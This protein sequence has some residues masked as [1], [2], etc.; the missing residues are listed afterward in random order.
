[1]TKPILT[2]G[3]SENCDYF[4]KGLKLSGMGSEFNVIKSSASFTKFD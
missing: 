1:M 3:F 2:Y 4:I